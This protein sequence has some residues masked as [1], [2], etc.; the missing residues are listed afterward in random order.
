MDPEKVKTRIAAMERYRTALRKLA[1][2]GLTSAK[3]SRIAIRLSVELGEKIEK[4]KEFLPVIE[5]IW[6]T[7]TDAVDRI[8]GWGRAIAGAYKTGMDAATKFNAKLQAAAGKLTKRME[9]FKEAS[10]EVWKETRTGAEKFQERLKLLFQLVQRGTKMGGIS[11]DTY[12]RAVKQAIGERD[13]EKVKTSPGEF[14]VLNPRL[15]NVAGMRGAMDPGLKQDA[16]RNEILQKTLNAIE[17]RK[18]LG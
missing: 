13:A 6:R 3:R 8:K 12:G 14:R 9:M 2:N 18:P 11:W 4:F 10:K 1:I 5:E 17:D 7:R 16:E 15:I